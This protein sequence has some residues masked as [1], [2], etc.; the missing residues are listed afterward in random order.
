MRK[1]LYSL[2]AITLSVTG[3]HAQDV[4]VLIIE[5]ETTPVTLSGSVD[6]YF[7]Y[8]LNSPNRAEDGDIRAPGTSFA[9]LAGLFAGYG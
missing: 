3:L 7:R 6:T 4:D 8:N 2:F 9:N 1:L 5:E